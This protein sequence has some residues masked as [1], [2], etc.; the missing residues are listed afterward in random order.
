[1]NWR[2]GGLNCKLL[3]GWSWWQWLK[4][5]RFQGRDA[6]L[7]KMVNQML[8]LH[9][10]PFLVVQRAEDHVVRPFAWIRSHVSVE[11]CPFFPKNIN[12]RLKA[13]GLERWQFTSRWHVWV[14]KILANG[15]VRVHELPHS[16]QFFFGRD[17]RH[18]PVFHRSVND[19]SQMLD[20]V[21][22]RHLAPSWLHVR[23][24]LSDQTVQPFFKKGIGVPLCQFLH[25]IEVFF[26]K[27]CFAKFRIAE[28]IIYEEKTATNE[29]F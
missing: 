12:C 28:Q 29:P 23:G 21:V 19:P 18:F 16:G 15:K 10:P 6:E 5:L 24:K 9:E 14:F 7:R 13:G 22:R 20:H 17:D 25:V 26:D 27:I 11:C 4:T 8:E 2:I 3:G 1:M